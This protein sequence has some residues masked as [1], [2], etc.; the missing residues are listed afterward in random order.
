MADPDLPDV[1][2]TQEPRSSENPATAPPASWAFNSSTPDSG[3]RS[4]IPR[5]SIFNSPSPSRFTPQPSTS[6]VLTPE[7]TRAIVEDEPARTSP[8]QLSILDSPSSA[9]EQRRNDRFEDEVRATVNRRRIPRVEKDA[10]DPTSPTTNRNSFSRQQTT[11]L[12]TLS[13]LFAVQGITS[14]TDSRAPSYYNQAD[15][16]H[17]RCELLHATHCA[18]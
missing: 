15:G 6:A 9:A 1:F 11:T 13:R 2:S 4:S 17:R 10:D 8:R 7:L 14:P 12:T 18:P 5:P 3:S 16:Q